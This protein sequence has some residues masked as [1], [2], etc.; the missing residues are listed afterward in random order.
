MKKIALIICWNLFFAT[1]MYAQGL[2]EQVAKL[3][4]ADGAADDYFG[5]SVSVSGDTALVGAYWDDDVEMSS[6]SA[7]VFQRD[8]GTETWQPVT[9]LT[10]SDPSNRGRFGT[11]VAIRGDMAVIGATDSGSGPGAAYIF[12]RNHGGTDNWG[13]VV[14]LTAA[15][16]EVADYFG[17]GVAIDGDTVAVGAYGDDDGGLGAGAAYIFGRDE[18]GAGNW[19]L[20]TKVVAD[21]ALAGDTLGLALS[22]DGNTLA[23]G[24]YLRDD[25]GIFS[26]SVFIFER[27]QGGTDNWGQVTKLDADDAAGGDYFG[28]AVSI[29]GD[30]VL[31][32]AFLNDDD[33]DASGSA[34]IFER[35]QGGA[36]S[37]GQVIKITAD[38]ASPSDRFGRHVALDG[39]TAVVGAYSHLIPGGGSGAA[40]LF[41]RNQ[42]GADNWGQVNKL[43][44]DDVATSDAFGWAVS[45]TGD[46]VLVGAYQD[47]DAGSSSGSAYVFRTPF[48]FDGFETGD[49]SAWSESQGLLP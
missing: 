13:Q 32:G 46:T 8:R 45:V 2:M 5:Y 35:D 7:Y 43:V 27:H 1:T 6:G 47:D 11:A 37:W 29:S 14:K 25:G 42:G 19:G 31:V 22:L 15:D 33:G 4:A 38:D 16:G 39:N 21:D 26:G 36:D 3:T 49:T 24:A 9:K 30:T 20:V 10:A 48:F 17:S 23:G 28:I 44:P 34:Y 40:Y 12:E 18:G 41:R